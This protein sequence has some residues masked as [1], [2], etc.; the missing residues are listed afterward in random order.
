MKTLKEIRTAL[1]L[2]KKHVCE[3]A[4]ISVHKLNNIEVN[5]SKRTKAVDLFNLVLFYKNNYEISVNEVNYG[6][7]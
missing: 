5:D 1:G 7:N 6:A 4:N 3:K 2:T